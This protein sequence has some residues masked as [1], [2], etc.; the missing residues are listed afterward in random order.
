MNTDLLFAVISALISFL[1]FFGIFKYM[2]HAFSIELPGW[3]VFILCLAIAFGLYFE[4]GI[5]FATP[6]ATGATIGFI[7]SLLWNIIDAGFMSW[8]F[9]GMFLLRVI[10]WALVIFLGIYK[11]EIMMDLWNKYITAGAQS[12]VPYLLILAVL[13]FL[14][15]SVFLLFPGVLNRSRNRNA[16]FRMARRASKSGVIFASILGALM[17]LIGSALLVEAY[18]FFIG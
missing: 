9:K 3:L 15:G 13:I 4:Q 18:N 6:I 14:T 11:R 5:F 12:A 16:G 1:I 17:T 7:I 2:N 8:L 10:I